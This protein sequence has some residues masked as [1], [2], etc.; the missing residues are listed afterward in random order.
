[1]CEFQIVQEGPVLSVRVVLRDGTDVAAMR[2]RLTGEL[3][4]NLA[5]LGVAEPTI[6]IERCE[7]L[8]RDPATMGK[9]KLVVAD[10]SASGPAEVL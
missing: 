1:V 7:K 9:L 10:R 8:E 5:A 3:T 4:G 2:R 6:R